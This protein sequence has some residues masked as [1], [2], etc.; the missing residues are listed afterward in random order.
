MNE[1]AL[2]YGCNPNQKPSRIYMEDG[3]DLPVTVL[4]GKPGYINFL[5]ALNSIQLV[6][7]L[8]AACG[9]PAAASFK[10]VSPAGA[11]LGLPL[12]DVERRMY[13]IAPD[14]ELS[15]LAC[16]Y[17]RARGADRMSSFG[18]WIALS[19]V[20]DVPTAKLIQH[21]VS[22][23]IIA[24]GYEPE[25]LTIL[26]GKKKGNY[27]VVAID[28]DY[29]PAPVEHKQVYGITFEQ[30][31]NELTINADTML[32]N[33]VTENKSVTEEQKRD[34]IIA[35]ITLKYTQSNSVCYTAGG[36]TIGVGAGQQSRI[37][38]TRLAGQK[39]DNWQL[40]HMPKVLNLP[41]RPDIAKPNRDN[42]IDVYIGDTPQDVIGDD[43]WAETFTEQPAPLTLDEKRAW[44]DA[45]TGVA[46]GSDAFFP[47][48][49]NIE[50]ARRSGVTAIVQPGGSITVSPESLTFAGEGAEAQRVAVTVSNPELTWTAAP[51][52]AAK[53]W[54]TVTADGDGISVSVSDN[55]ETDQR[56]GNII[57]TPG[58]D[59]VRPRAVRV[60]QEGKILPPSL[61][62]DPK[63]VPVF[64]YDGSV[65]RIITVTAVNCD[66]AVRVDYTEGD[67]GGW[68]KAQTIKTEA[69]SALSISVGRNETLEA[70]SASVT[71]YALGVENIPDIVIPV[72]QEAGK[73][74]F[75][76]LTGPVAISDMESLGALQY[77]ISPSQ[78]WDT[79]NPGTSWIMDMWSSGVSQESDLFGNQSFLG[80]GTRIYLKLFSENIPF[81]DD[82][83]FTLPAS[84]V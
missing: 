46:L 81:N 66:W 34:L 58:L 3:S 73:E 48:G 7:E 53:E 79:T 28:P 5:D 39:A 10:H 11:A 67:A 76:T 56:S 47:F 9:L 45:V 52:D 61:D 21:E 15:P 63:E 75:S 50:R 13:H 49:D 78:T 64:A 18:D 12:T 35:L 2:K 51:E 24:P 57:I 60:V 36:Q 6:K 83:E 26:A 62:A 43:V 42:A 20:C 74:F 19:D 68:V 44:L 16:A 17:A 77:H 54:I 72:S 27:N 33:W 23:G 40:R 37:H 38:C 14:F 82:Q 59:D 71:V 1:L 22:D 84:I 41:F 55:P 69:H 65:E 32:T 70:R 30:G 8:K 80:S 25:A 29:K 4:N 31:R